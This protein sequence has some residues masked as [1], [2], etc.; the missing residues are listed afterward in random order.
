MFIFLY[1]KQCP[2]GFTFLLF[3]FIKIINSSRHRDTDLSSQFSDTDWWISVTLSGGLYKFQANWKRKKKKFL[4]C[5][6]NYS[7]DL[8]NSTI[9]ANSFGSN[10]LTDCAIESPVVMIYFLVCSFPQLSVCVQIPWHRVSPSK[11]STADCSSSAWQDW[12]MGPNG[13]GVW[14]WGRALPMENRSSIVDGQLCPL[15]SARPPLSLSACLALT[16]SLAKFVS[17]KQ[18]N[19]LKLPSLR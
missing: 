18:T 13:R 8:I 12:G 3:F 10:S 9:P 1:N 19:S 4:V 11:A 15:S 6:W 2:H 14:S 5:W 17:P 16:Q 7:L